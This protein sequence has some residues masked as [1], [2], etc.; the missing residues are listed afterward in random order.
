MAQSAHDGPAG[1]RGAAHDTLA[2]AV[3]RAVG[4]TSVLDC[5]QC[6]RCAAGCM[7]NV[8]GEMDLSPTRIM[9]LLQLESAFSGEPDRAAGYAAQA[10][11]S[12]TCWLCAGC[13][14]CTTRCPQEVD[15]A[16]TM[17]VL[18]QEGLRRGVASTSKRARDI[19]ALHRAF[20][21]GALGRGRVHE[22]SLVMS[23]KLHT[24]HLFQDALLAPAMLRR[25][26]L[27]VLPGESSPTD[28]VRRAIEN[29]KEEEGSSNA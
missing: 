4:G 28:G 22:L 19:Q 9:R 18:R 11:G 1:S 7:Q 15:I 16:A 20:L 27:H 10:L 21:A 26:K 12:D 13:L 14:A 17:D 3:Q 29:L 2:A 24:G 8:A 23:Y 6:G 5:Y 25:G